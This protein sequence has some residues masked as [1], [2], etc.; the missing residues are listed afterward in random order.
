MFHLPVEILTVEASVSLTAC[1]LFRLFSCYWVA[2][3]SPVKKDFLLVLL[4][5]VFI[6]LDCKL[7]E[8][9]FFSWGNGREVDIWKRGGR[10]VIRIL[11]GLKNKN[12][13]FW[14]NA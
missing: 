5:L 11:V 3:S 7:L 10:S 8:A 2:L 4:C 12:P 14:V 9:Y 1:L 6:L 13:E